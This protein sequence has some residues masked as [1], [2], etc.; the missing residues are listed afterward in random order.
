MHHQPVHQLLN[1]ARESFFQTAALSE[2]E[3]WLYQAERAIKLAEKRAQLRAKVTGLA[4]Q[5]PEFLDELKNIL[6]RLHL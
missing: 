5:N 2:E 6:N 1:Q 4:T 3:S